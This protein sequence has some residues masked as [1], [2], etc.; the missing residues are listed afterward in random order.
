LIV[1]FVFSIIISYTHSYKVF[2]FFNLNTVTNDESR[3]QDY[4]SWD[5]YSWFLYIADKNNEAIEANENAQKAV[6]EYLKTTHSKE[7]VNYM[8]IIKQHEEQI[9]N[10]NW[11]SY[12]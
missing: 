4:Y 8:S 5:K 11:A 1:Y 7:A 2:Y 10:G 6:T 3:N 12:P 9:K